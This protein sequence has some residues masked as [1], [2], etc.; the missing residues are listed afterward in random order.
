MI[1]L[2]DHWQFSENWNEDF[3]NGK[4]KDAVEVRIPHTVKMLPQHYADD[5]DYQMISGYRRKV[6]IPKEAKGKRIFL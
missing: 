1:S 5:K 4:S 6:L 2:N 3:L